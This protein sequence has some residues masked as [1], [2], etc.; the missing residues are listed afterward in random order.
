MAVAIVAVCENERVAATNPCGMTGS[1]SFFVKIDS[2]D[3]LCAAVADW[4]HRFGDRKVAGR[5][6][7]CEDEYRQGY[8]YSAHTRCHQSHNFARS[9]HPCETEHHPDYRCDREQ[10]CQVSGTAEHQI[11]E[12]RADGVTGSDQIQAVCGIS[13]KEDQNEHRDANQKRLGYCLKKQAESKRKGHA[14]N[15]GSNC[16]LV[17]NAP[18]CFGRGAKL[19]SRPSRSNALIKNGRT[20]A[21]ENARSGNAALK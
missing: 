18:K 4:R 13:E 19:T 14:L 10:L 15:Q 3:G 21:P 2:Y 1:R 6:Q 8:L 9:V 12:S 5:H 11:S 16:S 7:T 20:A 17:A